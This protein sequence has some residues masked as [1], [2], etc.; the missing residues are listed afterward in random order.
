MNYLIGVLWRLNAIMYTEDFIQCQPYISIELLLL[1]FLSIGFTTSTGI[2]LI[3]TGVNIIS[4]YD[5]HSMIV[6]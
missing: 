4:A 6:K 1:F 2:W 3:H 5:K